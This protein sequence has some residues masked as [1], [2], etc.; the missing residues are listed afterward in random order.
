MFCM[1]EVE[2]ISNNMFELASSGGSFFGVEKLTAKLIFDT[3]DGSSILGI[4]FWCDIFCYNNM[5]LDKAFDKD[6]ELMQSLS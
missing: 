3:T 6:M 4:S 1:V 5:L 2:V